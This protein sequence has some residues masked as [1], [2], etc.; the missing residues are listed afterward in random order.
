MDRNKAPYKT[1]KSLYES[2]EIFN[3]KNKK[4]EVPESMVKSFGEGAKTMLYIDPYGIIPD[5]IK[6]YKEAMDL[7][8]KYEIHLLSCESI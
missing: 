3:P 8:D 5:A 7:K 2:V 1:N 6:G 4:I